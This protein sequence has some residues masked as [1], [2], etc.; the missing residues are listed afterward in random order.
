[1]SSGRG[2]LEHPFRAFLAGD[3]GKIGNIRNPSLCAL[4]SDALRIFKRDG[5]AV[6]PEFEGFGRLGKAFRSECPYSGDS[7]GFERVSERKQEV[8][9]SAFDER[10]RMRDDASDFPKVPVEGQF[11]Q[12]RD[13][14]EVAVRQ[15]AF[16]RN[17]SERDGEIERRSRFSYFCG[18]EI[19]GHPFLREGKSRIPYRGTHPFTTLLY[20]RVA[21]ADDGERRKSG[22]DVHFD[23]NGMSRQSANRRGEYGFDHKKSAE[24]DIFALPKPIIPETGHS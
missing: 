9:F 13:S 20:G 17:D 1:M 4:R 16:F 21:E 22:G 6:S 7:R 14:F 18:S 12:N 8:G 15:A 5:F 10:R 19:D 24:N 2:D 3:I 11:A 23:G